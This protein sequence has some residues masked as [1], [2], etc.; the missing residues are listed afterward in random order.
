MCRG[1]D[2]SL[3]LPRKNWPDVS[4]LPAQKSVNNVVSL[5]FLDCTRTN[6]H[7]DV[8]RVCRQLEARERQP[9]SALGYPSVVRLEMQSVPMY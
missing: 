4:R 6:L 3:T 8:W 9:L 5:C 7:L 1:G 2:I